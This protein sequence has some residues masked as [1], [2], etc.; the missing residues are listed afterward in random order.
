MGGRRAVTHRRRGLRGGAA[1]GRRRNEGNQGNAAADTAAARF[2]DDCG[3]DG[4][5]MS[6]QFLDDGVRDACVCGGTCKPLP[7]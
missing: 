3:G 2:R 4:G 1:A 5:Q 7:A 6:L